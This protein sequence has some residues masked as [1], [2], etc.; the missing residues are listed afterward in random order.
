MRAEF[1]DL[2]EIVGAY[3]ERE[4]QFACGLVDVQPCV[5]QAYEVVVACRKGECQLLDDGRTRVAER[6]PRNSYDAHVLVLLGL[7]DQL[8]DAGDALFTVGRAEIAFRRKPFYQRVDAECDADILL[9]DALLFD[10]GQDELGDMGRLL[11]A[12]GDFDSLNTDVLE[13][14][15]EVCG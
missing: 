7:V 3:R 4:A 14:R 1:G 11:S 15:V 8:D 13:Q 5:H 2:H 9:G 10:F 12:E 6:L